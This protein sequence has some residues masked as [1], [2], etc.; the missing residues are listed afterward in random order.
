M[1][2]PKTPDRKGRKISSVRSTP[3]RPVRTT[4]PITP[5]KDGGESGWVRY[6]DEASGYY[7]YAKVMWEEPDDWVDHKDVPSEDNIA[8]GTPI[9]GQS[10]RPQM[11]QPAN[12]RSEGCWNYSLLGL[13]IVVVLALVLFNTMTL[14]ELVNVSNP[15]HFPL[16]FVELALGLKQPFSI[17]CMYSLSNINDSTQITTKADGIM[18]K[19]HQR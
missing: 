4:E 17:R 5:G 13:F 2:D 7:Y 19:P 16:D 15:L 8:I 11:Y 3:I 10:L 18:L 1:Q 9:H 14:S 12:T 6:Y